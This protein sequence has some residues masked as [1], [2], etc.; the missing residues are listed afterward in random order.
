MDLVRVPSK[1]AAL[2]FGLR[3]TV[4]DPFEKYH[5]QVAKWRAEG[6]LEH[7]RY[8]L[9]G[10]PVYGLV[11]DGLGE[12][13]KLQVRGLRVVAAAACAAKLPQLAGKT[14]L[15]LIS[16][17]GSATV[18]T[19]GLDRGMVVLDRLCDGS[20][21]LA[22]TRQAF[23][24][25]VKQP[26]YEVFG[27][28][29]Q[30]HHQLELEDLIQ[31][32]GLLGREPELR[33]LRARRGY[34][35]AAGVAVSG[36]LATVGVA[37]WDSHRAEI[38]QRTQLEML[39]RNKPEYQYRQAIQ[40][41]LQRPVVPLAAA[42]E[43]TRDAFFDFPLVHAGWE[44]TRISCPASGDCAVQFKRM[45]GSGAS[46]DEFRRTAAPHWHG[47]A[48]AGQE[49]VSFVVKIE[50]TPTKL[51]RETWPKASE[52]RDRSYAS[53]QFLEPGGWRAEFGNT[54]IQAVP[55]AI[56]PKDFTALHGLHEAVFAMPVTISNQPW[57][58]AKT[59]P[60][61]PVRHELLGEHTVMEAE[62]QI[63]IT[64]SNKQI[65]FSARGLSY[66]QR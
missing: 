21:Q 40:A 39:E 50:F 4:V 36:L 64:H 32:G 57:W 8:E 65:S 31:K 3:W 16:L 2:A 22:E 28:T 38:Q 34:K 58:Y 56:P 25:S 48:A 17:P 66:V 29:G 23:A 1:K 45:V 52:F 19:I 20:T 43:T 6:F 5:Q 46:L 49:E 51:R 7:A 18:A 30:V 24:Q 26:E 13:E 15:V 10:D 35:L 37:A 61:S 9:D 59:D 47:I 44:L 33:Q 41:L 11:K 63:E 42:I 54:S 14:A 55:P 27:N 53:W 60:D 12:Q 62:S